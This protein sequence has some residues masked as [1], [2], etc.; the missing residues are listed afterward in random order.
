MLAFFCILVYTAISKLEASVPPRN[1]KND[2]AVTSHLP[3][4]DVK[5]FLRELSC[6]HGSPRELAT[7][8][9]LN[10]LLCRIGVCVLDVDFTDAVVDAGSGGARDLD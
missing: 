5:A 7:R 1:R 10:G 3:S 9:R 6:D 8:K 2:R 4:L